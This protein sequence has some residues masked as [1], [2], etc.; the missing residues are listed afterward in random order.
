MNKIR[1]LIVDDEPLAR[2]GLVLRLEKYEDVEVV[3]ECSNGYE[4]LDCIAKLQPDLIFLDIE[5]PGIDGF[6]V[7][8]RMQADI[9]GLVVFVT[10]FDQY[11]VDAFEVHAIDYLLKPL[12]NER[13]CI[14]VDRVRSH[15]ERSGALSDKKNLMDMMA[16]ITDESSNHTHEILN[17][18]NLSPQGYPEKL[19]IKEG[20]VTVLLSCNEIAWVDAAGD[21]MCVHANNQVHILR[22]TMKALEKKLDPKLFQRIHRSTIVNLAMIKEVYAHINGEFFLI[23]KDDSRLK[24]SRSY[25][26]SIKYII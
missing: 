26:D 12:E 19:A 14:A 21:Y 2:R 5:M 18:G 11:A 4:A 24:M 7:V 9:M 10:A 22:S 16:S 23:L 13:L 6:E 8:R 15:L 1:A 17:K 20:D 25:K 3:R